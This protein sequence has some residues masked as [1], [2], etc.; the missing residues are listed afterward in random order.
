M[1]E[2]LK[3]L[4]EQ[5]KH[6]TGKNAFNAWSKE[7]ILKKM[8]EHEPTLDS[9]PEDG[10]EEEGESDDGFQTATLKL[11]QKDT[12]SPLGVVV[13]FK[14]LRFDYDENSRQHDKDI[15][16]FTV[17]YDDGTTEKVQ[18]PIIDFGHIDCEAW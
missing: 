6:L 18:M 11:W 10:W 3:P 12:N 15:Y 5:Y 8:E 4:R 17:M 2:D 14:H 1:S 7:Q 16:E 9:T 13:D